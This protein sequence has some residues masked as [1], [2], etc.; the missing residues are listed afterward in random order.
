MANIDIA[1]N[2]LKCTFHEFQQYKVIKKTYIYAH[3]LN[4]CKKKLMR[5]LKYSSIR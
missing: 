5:H 3:I 2:V 1:K 4:I